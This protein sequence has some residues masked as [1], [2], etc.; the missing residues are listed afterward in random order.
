MEA[1]FAVSAALGAG[2]SAWLGLGGCARAE[3]PG[4]HG[5]L[6]RLAWLWAERAL[7]ALGHSR[8]AA[9][10]GSLTV[11][12]RLSSRLVGR[13]QGIGREMDHAQAL[14]ILVAA[15]VCAAVL[16]GVLFASV[17]AAACGFVAVVALALAWDASER[18]RLAKEASAQMPGVYRALASALGSGQTLAQ[19]IE[20]VGEHE[21]EPCARAFRSM[22][23]RL[24]CGSSTQEASARLAV[25]LGVPGADLLATALV[26]SHKTGS[27][28]RGLLQRSARLV[29]RQGEFERMLAVKTA[30]VRLSVKIVCLMPVVM[31]GL[32]SLVSPDFQEGLLTPVG[33]G[34]V[35]LACVLDGTALL[36]IRRMVRGVL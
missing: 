9:A 2:A 14:G 24:R 30:Q 32:L 15:P 10:L 22:G 21:R 5:R 23:L 19:A 13:A 8:A 16:A 31:I 35:A 36:I 28:L 4:A 6:K 3:R 1:L 11:A 20:Y 29:E 7:C 12:S 18:R 34:S 25:D 33:V 27:P 26:I 17:A